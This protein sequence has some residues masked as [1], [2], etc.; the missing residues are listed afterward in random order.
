MAIFPMIYT[1]NIPRKMK[2][3]LRRAEPR[4]VMGQSLDSAMPEENLPQDFTIS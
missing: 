4:D 2:A 3:I 1:R